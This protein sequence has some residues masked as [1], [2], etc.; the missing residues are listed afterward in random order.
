MTMCPPRPAAHMAAAKVRTA[1]TVPPMFTPQ[2]E[3]PVLVGG[4][5]RRPYEIHSGV[6]AEQV[7][8]AEIALHALRRSRPTAAGR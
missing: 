3:V 5:L 4:C 2:R 7:H 6:T 8:A 1:L